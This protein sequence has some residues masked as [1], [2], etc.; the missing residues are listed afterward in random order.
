MEKILKSALLE[1][2]GNDST[3]DK[4]IA[5]LKAMTPETASK[6]V[7]I[8]DTKYKVSILYGSTIQIKSKLDFGNDIKASIKH[9]IWLEGLYLKLQADKTVVTNVKGV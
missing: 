9:S 7:D 1:Y 6:G 8:V 3:V 4:V 5:E 2:I